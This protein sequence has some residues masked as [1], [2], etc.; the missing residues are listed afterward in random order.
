MDL[1]NI[2]L[3]DFVRYILS[4][5]NFIVFII[6]LPSIYFSPS[7][8][9]DLLSGNSVLALFLGSISVGYLMDILKVYQL[10]PRFQKNKT[11]FRT[12]IAQILDVSVED[13]ARYVSITSKLWSEHSSYNLDQRRA[14]WVLTLHT[15][16]TFSISVFIW[17]FAAVYEYINSENFSSSL[18]L[19]IAI[20]FIS[21]ILSIR[22]FR[23]GRREIQKS[24][25]EFFLILNS[26]KKKILNAW[27][28][29]LQKK[30]VG[31]K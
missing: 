16:V 25:Q 13:A 18:I 12:A 10:A 21:L 31:E 8:L 3:S 29:D 17:G 11:K 19:P 22:L 14:E 30:I 1:K 27:K 2:N 9:I 15:A 24:D 23:I 28:M 6:V 4:G 20:A 26:N 7:L 5:F